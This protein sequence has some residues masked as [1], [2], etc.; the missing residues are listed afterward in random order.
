MRSRYFRRFVGQSVVVALLAGFVLTLTVV[1]NEAQTTTQPSGGT[2]QPIVENQFTTTSGGAL[3][4]RAPGIYTQQAIA[5]Q[6]GDLVLDG[7]GIPDQP[8][9]PRQLFDDLLLQFIDILISIVDGLN[10]VA[11]GN[12]LTGGTGGLGGLLDGIL[13]NPLTTNSGGSTP[14]Q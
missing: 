13:S 11:G 7:S 8:S 14:I 5:V 10:L 3:Q 4:A 9:F 1:P 12:P 6:E 2:R